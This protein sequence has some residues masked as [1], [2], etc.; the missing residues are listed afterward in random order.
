LLSHRPEGDEVR[1]SRDAE[2]GQEGETRYRNERLLVSLGK[3]HCLKSVE[4]D[5]SFFLKA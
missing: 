5:L 1:E 3:V 2:Q 4:A